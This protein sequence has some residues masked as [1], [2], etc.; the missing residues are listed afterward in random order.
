MNRSGPKEVKTSMESLE[1]KVGRLTSCLHDIKGLGVKISVEQRGVLRQLV[2]QAAAELED[3]KE[4]LICSVSDQLSPR[5]VAV[6]QGE[7]EEGEREQEGIEWDSVFARCFNLSINLRIFR[8]KLELGMVDHITLA[9]ILSDLRKV[10]NEL[11]SHAEAILSGE[12]SPT[13]SP[14]GRLAGSTTGIELAG[15]RSVK[16]KKNKT[17]NLATKISNTVFRP[18]K[19]RKTSMIK[20]LSASLLKLKIQ[21]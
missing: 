16:Y 17:E 12:M 9:I 2:G 14:M 10:Q 21:S 15:A 4:F 1:E 5:Q 13:L 18:E 6:I 19:G 8:Q 11:D 3:V 7:E 20:T